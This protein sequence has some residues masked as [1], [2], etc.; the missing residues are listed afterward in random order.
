MTEVINDAELAAILDVIHRETRAFWDKDF[1][2]WADCWAHVPYARTMGYW[3][4]GGIKVVE[5]W[6]AQ[7]ALIRHMMEENPAPNPTAGRYRRENLNGRIFADVAWI[8][9]DQYGIDTGDPLFD[10]PGRSR[11]TRILERHDDRWKI[12][13]VGWMLEGDASQH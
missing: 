13:Y 6:D 2:A 4:L 7:R 8:T 12:V 1:D 9:Y 11:E 3:P 10:M 5:G